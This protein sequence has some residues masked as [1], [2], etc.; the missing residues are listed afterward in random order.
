[1][2]WKNWSISFKY[3]TNIL[4]QE[5][6]WIKVTLLG[7]NY[8]AFALSQFCSNLILFFVL[9]LGRGN[10][11]ENC[12]MYEMILIFDVIVAALS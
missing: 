5:T 11:P 7:R 1:M 3:L 9:F 12:W 8:N 2:M 4:P 6:Q 10:T